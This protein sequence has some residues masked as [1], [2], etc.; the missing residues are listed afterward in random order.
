MLHNRLLIL[1][2]LLTL[3]PTTVQAQAW[4]NGFSYRRKLTIDKSKVTA[5]IYY[6]TP[7][8]TT[9][10]DQINFPVFIE[11]IDKSLIFKTG[12]CG[13]KIQDS[14]GRDISFA[15]VTAPT[16]PLNF[17]LEEYDP[18]TGKIRCW[19]KINNLSAAKTITPATEIFLYYGGTVLHNSN[20]SA[21][22]QTWN[23]DFTKVWHMNSVSQQV[24]IHQINASLT[25]GNATFTEGKL[26][27]ATSF[28]GISSSYIGNNELN[29]TF[30]VTAWIK[31]NAFGREQMIV[32]NDSAGVGGFQFKVNAEGKLVLQT[33]SSLSAPIQTIGVSAIQTTGKWVYVCAVVKSGIL[34][35]YVDNR[36]SV[37]NSSSLIR[38][39]PGGRISIGVSKQNDRYFN[40]EIDEL[41][42]QKALLSKEW[43]E[44]CYTNQTNPIAF[45]IPGIEEYNTTGFSRF[46][47]T[48][49][50]WNLS[51]NWSGNFIPSAN[52]NILIAAG[53]KVIAPGAMIF[54]KLILETGSTI[55]INGDL[56]FTCLS[57]IANNGTLKVNDNG[58]LRFSGDVINKGLIIS[59]NAFSTVSFEGQ[60]L[61][62]E[63][64]G[65]GAA[66]IKILENHQ[67]STQNTL[68]LN[69]PINISGSVNL[70]KGI[71]KSNRTLIMK[72]TAQTEAASLLPVNIVEASING[73]V[74]VE[75]YISGA[76]PV[77]ATARGW[78]LLS[79]PVY[80]SDISSNKT[81][82]SQSYK[83]GL[84]VTGPG[85]INNGFDTSPQNGATIYTHDQSLTGT[86]S[87]KYT[88]IKSLFQKIEIGKGV[89]IFSRGSRHAANAF[90][91]QI[92]TQ[93]FINPES[94]I[95]K[96]V[97]K[98]FTGNLSVAL[99]NKDTG[100]AGDGFNLIGNPYASGLK[101]GNIVTENTTG[102]IWQF[103]PLNAAYVVGNSSDIIIPSGTA[104]FVRVATGQKFGT[105]DFSESSKII[106][107]APSIPVLQSLRNNSVSTNKNE[108]ILKITLSRDK[109]EQPY[110][111]RLTEEGFDGVN[112]LDA[113]KIGEGH[114]SIASTVDQVQLSVDSRQ[115]S[116]NPKAIDLNVT[117]TES[118]IYTLSFEHVFNTGNYSTTLVDTYLNVQKKMTAA[119]KS[120]QF[121]MDK[122]TSVSAE[123]MRFKVIIEQDDELFLL[124]ST[125]KI[126]PNP[127][128]DNINVKI[129]DNLNENMILT[130]SDMLGRTISTRNVKAGAATLLI[131][132]Q[133]FIAGN[134][135][136]RVVGEKTKNV[137]TTMK[138]I[139]Y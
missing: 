120:Y 69:A 13:S 54:N 65:T 82:D 25:N 109:F 7:Q 113:P 27:K 88:G 91:N 53:R 138:L 129:G 9:Y 89:Y 136:L 104:F 114:V 117:G 49:T 48:N 81:Y 41:R 90:V 3:I 16:V 29:V 61:E 64:T 30:S 17:Q 35:L 32:T 10:L 4:M 95:I 128:R 116:K 85:G 77:P 22:L 66:N 98:L 100:N 70:K 14:E 43:L 124:T 40:G 74:I 2:L 31:I 12:F 78:R 56:K 105:L 72:A 47:G 133:S 132:T 112:D 99:S 45:L 111:L 6:P 52:S 137:L 23:S 135:I 24:G 131:D 92:Q 60:G 11:I 84:F 127:F 59:N 130:I 63:Y 34:T 46:T 126:Y 37:T 50:Q 57:D 5:D 20:S 107:S 26:G 125:I 80:T 15:L 51:S 58:R 68:L 62:Q 102:F 139:K 86:L 108:L 101:W 71:L 18:L 87:Q 39:A 21:A 28:N 103:D 122:T 97:G 83:E 44:T 55:E 96:H 33:F 67:S 123:N 134:Y 38:P 1:L 42:I 94:Y 8:I 79:S 118:G 73:D 119:D 93:P 76:Y 36:I 115:S 19:V 75:Q 106:S 121:S 110:I